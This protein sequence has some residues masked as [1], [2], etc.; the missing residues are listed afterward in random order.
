MYVSMYV[1]ALLITYYVKLVRLSI[2]GCST[3]LV[4]NSTCLHNTHHQGC[5]HVPLL[6]PSR[7]WFA[8]QLVL[9]LIQHSK[10]CENA[11]AGDLWV[12]VTHI[13]QHTVEITQWI[14]PNTKPAESH[15]N[16]HGYTPSCP[17]VQLSKDLY[18]SI[19]VR[20]G[21]LYR[22]GLGSVLQ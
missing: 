9:A 1:Y 21:V 4:L 11:P 14:T 5:R 10:R 16:K 18:P 6:F 15:V 12:S 3:S 17:E 13:V 20:T 8:V 19:R 22:L 2:T 7:W